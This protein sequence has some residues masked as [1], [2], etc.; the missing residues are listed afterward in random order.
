MLANLT[1]ALAAREAAERGYWVVVVQDATAAETF[2]WHAATMLGI[3]G[4][5]IR[6]QWVEEVKEM[7]EGKRT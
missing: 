1:V 2:D 3:A 6:V 4:G 5:L 7:L